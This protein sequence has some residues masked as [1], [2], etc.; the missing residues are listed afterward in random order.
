[1]LRVAFILTYL[2]AAAAAVLLLEGNT[3]KGELAI[4]IWAVA[5]I[6]LGWGTG[7]PVLAVLAF[8]VVPFA[9]P[10]GY[11]NDYAYSE[12]LPIW[13]WVAVLSAFSAGVILLA[14]FARR[15]FELRRRPP[16]SI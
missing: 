13:W 11:P 6:L 12:P 5:S 15:I 14:A 1:M 3:G 9:I 7:Q 10:L 8:V 2:L 4:A 16:R